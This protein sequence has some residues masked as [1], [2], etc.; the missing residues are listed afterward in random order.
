[1]RCRKMMDCSSVD[2]NLV[3]DSAELEWEPPEYGSIAFWENHFAAA[4][5]GLA[6]DPAALQFEWLCHDLD[7]LIQLIKPHL[8]RDGCILHPGCGMSLLPLK[9]HDLGLDVLSVDSSSFCIQAMEEVSKKCTG[10]S[11]AVRDVRDIGAFSQDGVHLQFSGAVEKGCL[12][13]LLCD[14]DT[15][16]ASYVS[17]LARLLPSRS[18]LLLISNSPV[19]HRHLVP[20]F[21]VK[22][23]VPVFPDEAFGASLFVCERSE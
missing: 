7:V 21:T 13:A 9:I 8:P 1:M 14:S 20:F 16:A 22:E 18:P 23:V 4:P 15:S 17:E 10:L 2:E 12:D 19:R 11:W 3:D 6:S 5:N